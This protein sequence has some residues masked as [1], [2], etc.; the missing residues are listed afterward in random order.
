MNVKYNLE[1]FCPY[2][3]LFVYFIFLSVDTVYAEFSNKKT[4]MESD[5]GDLY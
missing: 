3:S 5:L 1:I 4:L 2:F